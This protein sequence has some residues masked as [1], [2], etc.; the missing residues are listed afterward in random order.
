MGARR[1]PL[2]ISITTAGADTNG[3]CYELYNYSK[4]QIGKKE[5]GEEY[6]KTFYPVIY[7]AP[8]DADIWDEKVWFAANPALGVFRS[9]EEFRQTAI[10]AKEIPSLEAGFRRLYLNQWVNSDVAWMDMAKWHLCNGFVPES[11]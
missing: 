5:R 11:E 4:M 6:D 8:A 7:E 9:I 2:F 1:Q 10:R 3:I